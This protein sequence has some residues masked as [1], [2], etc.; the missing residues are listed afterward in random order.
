MMGWIK[1]MKNKN[2]LKLSKEK[3]EQMKNEI[4]VYFSNERDED[5][6]DLGAGLILDF[7]IEELAPEFYNQGVF[8]AYQYMNDRMEDVLGLQK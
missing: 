5:L 4:K 1:P 2:N 7:I 3:R 8:D 6:G